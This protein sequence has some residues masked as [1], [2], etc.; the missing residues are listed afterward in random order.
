MT[1]GGYFKLNYRKLLMVNGGIILL[2]VISGYFRLNYHRLL[3]VISDYW[4]LLVPILLVNI[5]K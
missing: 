5:I 3:M 1:I 4:G 2:I